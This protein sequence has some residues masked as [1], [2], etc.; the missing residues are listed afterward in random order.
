M[1]KALKGHVREMKASHVRDGHARVSFE[2]MENALTIQAF[3]IE[4]SPFLSSLFPDGLEQDS[5]TQDSDVD[6]DY[7]IPLPDEPTPLAV[8]TQAMTRRSKEGSDE[9]P[10]LF[11]L[12]NFTNPTRLRAGSGEN[13]PPPNKMLP[14]TDHISTSQAGLLQPLHQPF[15][16]SAPL[17]AKSISSGGT[18]AF[19]GVPGSLPNVPSHHGRVSRAFVNTL[20][21]FGRWK[22]KLSG[23]STVP[24]PRAPDGEPEWDLELNATG[25]AFTVRGGLNEYLKR[26]DLP[27]IADPGTPRPVRSSL[28]EAESRTSMSSGDGMRVESAREVRPVTQFSMFINVS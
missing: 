23:R 20:G 16:L 24:M 5:F 28:D 3:T 21:K 6:L 27:P 7:S 1:I 14:Q 12:G 4:W 13:V 2:R 9:L 11:P 22:G 18:S 25:D 8:G 10:T 15:N 19:S 26:M 17:M